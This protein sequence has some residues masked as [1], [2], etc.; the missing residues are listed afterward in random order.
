MKLQCSKNHCESI[1][2]DS[3]IRDDC[4]LDNGYMNFTDPR[5]RNLRSQEERQI[6]SEQL[7]PL[8]NHNSE[9]N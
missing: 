6:L 4:S 7:K 8:K 9:L 5:T 2:Q 3:D 1:K